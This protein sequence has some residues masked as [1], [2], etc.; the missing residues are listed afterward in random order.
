MA[1]PNTNSNEFTPAGVS[2]FALEAGTPYI[3]QPEAEYT[4]SEYPYAAMSHDPFLGIAETAGLHPEAFTSIRTDFHRAVSDISAQATLLAKR[5]KAWFKDDPRAQAANA[6]AKTIAPV[7]EYDKSSRWPGEKTLDFLSEHKRA[8]VV[9]LL[10]AAL[11]PVFAACNGISQSEIAPYEMANLSFD[12]L[13]ELNPGAVDFMFPTSYEDEAQQQSFNENLGA[14]LAHQINAQRYPDGV[15]EDG[16]VIVGVG[17]Y[18][19]EGDYDIEAAS[20]P[21][22]QFGERPFRMMEDGDDLDQYYTAAATSV[23]RRM[24]G[25][26]NCK[27]RVRRDKRGRIYTTTTN[28]G[29]TTESITMSDGT[30]IEFP[31]SQSDPFTIIPGTTG[32]G[33]DPTAGQTNTTESS[34]S[35]TSETSTSKTSASETTRGKEM[36]P[37]ELL[38]N[39]NQI[40]NIGEVGPN[41]RAFSKFANGGFNLAIPTNGKT[42]VFRRADDLN[43]KDYFENQFKNGKT[44]TVGI[45]RVTGYKDGKAVLQQINTYRYTIGGSG[46]E[47]GYEVYIVPDRNDKKQFPNYPDPLVKSIEIRVGGNTGMPFTYWV[48]DNTN[49]LPDKKT[50]FLN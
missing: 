5:A 10:G 24:K 13:M 38:L 26:P 18:D 39:N 14:A 29:E 50:I 47:T 49:T 45:Y 42:Y 15:P 11:V 20:V 33:P 9:P 7:G 36:Y 19:L 3:E 37:Q 40:I 48:H 16:G 6:R 30:T 41:N 12:E 25:N 8:V 1:A 27:F 2:P 4:E 22:I 21:T 28:P 23:I 46:S 34:S 35:S 17:S 31:S 44:E 43:K 32:E